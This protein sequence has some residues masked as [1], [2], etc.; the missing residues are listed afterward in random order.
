[1]MTCQEVAHAIASDALMDAPLRR[2]LAVR[3][4]LMLCR[5]CHRYARQIRAIGTGA[6]QLFGGVEEPPETI[7][8]LRTAILRRQDPNDQGS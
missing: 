8:R 6:R 2:R 5:R 4:H 3:M 1:M 7:E